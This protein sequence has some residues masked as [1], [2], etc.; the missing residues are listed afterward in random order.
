MLMA[1]HISWMTLAGSPVNRSSWVRAFRA[2]V[3][4]LSSSSWVALSSISRTLSMPPPSSPGCRRPPPV[5][6]PPSQCPSPPP[7]P[8]PW[9]GPEWRWSGRN[10]CR[11][12]W[13]RLPWVEHSLFFF[14]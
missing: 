9:S 2:C 12:E 5:P 6:Q 11:W 7:A 8:C 14:L 1:L 13:V 10:G 3:A 4:T